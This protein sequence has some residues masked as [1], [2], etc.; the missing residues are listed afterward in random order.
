MTSHSPFP[1]RKQKFSASHCV[2]V[3]GK[4]TQ[5]SQGCSVGAKA[6]LNLEIRSRRI[7]PVTT[8]CR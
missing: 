2:S 4:C 5:A 7:T 3:M 8:E 6:K 1:Q